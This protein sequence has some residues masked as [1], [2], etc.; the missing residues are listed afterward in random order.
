M[1]LQGNLVGP[2]HVGPPVLPLVPAML[3][4]M[5]GEMAGYQRLIVNWPQFGPLLEA[6]MCAALQDAIAAT[7]RQCG[8]V[9]VGSCPYAVIYLRNI[10][11][12]V[13]V[14]VSCS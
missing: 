8:L 12:A 13:S 11:L 3:E 9:Q 10:A 2:L 6:S 5:D 14:L 1:P 4:A 7:A